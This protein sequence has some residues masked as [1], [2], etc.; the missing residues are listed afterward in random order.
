MHDIYSTE[1]IARSRAR[2]KSIR[3]Q[4]A[5]R[6]LP[7]SWLVTADEI[8]NYASDRERIRL[9]PD[10]WLVTAEAAHY[11]EPVDPA[12]ATNCQACQ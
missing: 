12:E 3:S 9:L 8:D 5:N 6:Q 2:A 11:L 7:D 4:V 10:S 1:N